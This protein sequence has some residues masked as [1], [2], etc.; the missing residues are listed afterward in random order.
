MRAQ[1][2]LAADQ[3]LSDGGIASTVG[4]GGST[5]YRTRQRFV[6]G[7]LDQA[8]RAGRSGARPNG[9]ASSWQDVPKHQGGDAKYD[10]HD[11]Y[12][13]PAEDRVVLVPQFVA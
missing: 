2:L 9:A 7:N 8:R 13:D 10:G 6:E 5:V 3:G 4:V 1:I 12:R 11:R